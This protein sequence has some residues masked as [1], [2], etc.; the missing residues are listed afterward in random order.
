L[1]R[2]LVYKIKVLQGYQRILD[3]K[4]SKHFMEGRAKGNKRFYEGGRWRCAL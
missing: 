2:R 4:K 3:P 1:G